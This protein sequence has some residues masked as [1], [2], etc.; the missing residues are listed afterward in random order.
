MVNAALTEQIQSVYIMNTTAF[1]LYGS[2]GFFANKADNVKGVIFDWSS[3][4]GK[5]E[6]N[7]FFSIY[8]VLFSDTIFNEMFKR[9]RKISR[10]NTTKFIKSNIDKKM[11]IERKQT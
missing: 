3:G 5:L 7:L 8:L 2:L 6:N 9:F 11:K 10:I 1:I 4:K